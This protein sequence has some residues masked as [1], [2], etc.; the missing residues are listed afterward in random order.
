MKLYSSPMSIIS[1]GIDEVGLPPELT[2]ILAKLTHTRR[3][4]E[5]RGV[6]EE[7]TMEDARQH[8]AKLDLAAQAINVEA[9][10]VDRI[11]L[12]TQLLVHELPELINPDYTPGEISLEEKMRIERESIQKALPVGFPRREEI[13][14]HWED[15]EKGGLAYLLDK[16]DA[17]VTSYYYAVVNPKEYAK[18]AAEF[19][20]HALARVKD[21]RLLLILEDIREA[22][23][24]GRLTRTTI[25]PYYFEMLRMIKG[26]RSS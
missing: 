24:Q 21:Q 2:P 17:V 10:D 19:H 15:Y 26:G 13:I 25:F 8:V 12:R 23:I 9:F 5:K 16:M 1:K 18:V 6:N 14:Q 3:G 20:Q 22:V 11:I 7:G 4:W